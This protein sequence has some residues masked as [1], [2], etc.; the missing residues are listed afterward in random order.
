MYENEKMLLNKLCQT[1]NAA[2]QQ[3]LADELSANGIRY[4]NWGNMALVVPS[5]AEKV[6]VLSAHYDVV[7]GSLGFAHHGIGFGIRFDRKLFRQSPYPHC[8]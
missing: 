8:S 3:A 1:T 5:A 7:D 6:I 4:E 2:R